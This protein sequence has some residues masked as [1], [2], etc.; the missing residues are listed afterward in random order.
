[1]DETLSV[2]PSDKLQ[3]ATLAKYGGE[4]VVHSVHSFRL[5]AEVPGRTGAVAIAALAL[6]PLA[7]LRRQAPLG[8]V[9]PRRRRGRS[10]R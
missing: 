4:L 7:G 5:A 2:N 1:M 9:R 10:W 3:A 6:V 8:R